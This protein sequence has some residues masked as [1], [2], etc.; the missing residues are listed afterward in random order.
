[1]A[2]EG[3]TSLMGSVVE[4]GEYNS[5]KINEEVSIDILQISTDTTIIKDG[6][7]DNL[8]SIRVIL[9]GFEMIFG[10]RVNFCKSNVYGSIPRRLQ[11]WVKDGMN[12]FLWFSKWVGCQPLKDVF[13][14]LFAL[15]ADPVCSIID[16]EQWVDEFLEVEMAW[17]RGFEEL[18][19]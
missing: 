17:C 9:R 3:L 13:S 18:E 12:T 8:W 7:S 16:A 5:F 4:A 15:A 1:M 10:L 11:L 19:C 6:S 2:M 14:K